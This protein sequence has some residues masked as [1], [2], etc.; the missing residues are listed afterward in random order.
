MQPLFEGDIGRRRSGLVGALL[1]LMAFA[2]TFV[3]RWPDWDERTNVYNIEASY[4]VLL[5][6]E[7]LDRTPAASHRYLPIVSLG[8]PQD[9]HIAWGGAVLAPD[10]NAYYTSFFPAGFVVPYSLFKLFGAPFTLRN[11]ALFN[12]AL[13]FA[14]ALLFYLLALRIG[15]RLFPDNRG[16]SWNAALATTPLIFSNQALLSTGLLYWSQNVYQL[17]LTATCH[18]MVSLLGGGR[19]ERG[20]QAA[21]LLLAFIGPLLEWTALLTNGALVLA[22]AL[23][24]NHVSARNRFGLAAGVAV[25]T[26]L[27]LAFVALHFASVI[28]LE[29]FLDALQARFAQRAFSHEPLGLA[30]SY[31]RSFGFFLPLFAVAGLLVLKRLVAFRDDLGR[32]IV[33]AVALI[34]LGACME[35]IV[36]WQHASQFGFDRLKAGTLMGVALLVALSGSGGLLRLALQLAVAGCCLWGLRG[37]SKELRAYPESSLLHRQNEMLRARIDALVDRKCAVFATPDDVRGYTSLLFMRA[38]HEYVSPDMFGALVASG[39]G[40]GWV[41]LVRKKTG[42]DEYAYER[43]L[44]VGKD[45]TISM[46]APFAA[47]T[48]GN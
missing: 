6:M 20:A 4:H 46:I 21:L 9:K 29:P 30:F 48:A 13:G 14:S 40:C 22:L 44:V 12:C 33:L 43:A 41:Y 47:P 42:F 11:L 10:G 3:W 1:V 19:R 5:T 36:L 15:H 38:V 17:V 16:N 25:A 24:R 8:L 35:N 28:G 39:K 23:V 2:A 27:S 37:Y 45:G 26:L 31:W 18:A 7:A 32:R 34:L